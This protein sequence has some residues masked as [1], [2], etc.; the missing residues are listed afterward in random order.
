MKAVFTAY[1]AKGLSV[2]R[3]ADNNASIRQESMRADNHTHFSADPRPQPHY[4]YMSNL[5]MLDHLRGIL[6]QPIDETARRMA[7]CFVNWLGD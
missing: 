1:A 5:R 3:T 7:G 6:V 2:G 4:H